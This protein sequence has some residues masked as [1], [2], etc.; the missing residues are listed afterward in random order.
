MKEE[1]LQKTSK[2]KSA[3]TIV[4]I[5]ALAAASIVFGVLYI[6]RTGIDFI[7][8]HSLLIEIL[9]SAIIAVSAV[10]AIVFLTTNKELVYKF[11][12]I[13][14]ALATIFLFIMYIIC[15][16]GLWDKI[17]SIEDLREYVAGYGAYTIPVFILI[18]FLQVVLLPIPG[19]VTIGAGVALFGPFYGSLY[20]F[21][22][23]TSASFVAFF[24]GRKLGV[25]VASWLVGKETLDKWLEIVKGKDKVALTFM[26][27]FPFFPDD[28]LCFVAGLSTM[29]AGYYSVMIVIARLL[30]VFVTSYSFNGNII[31]YNTWWGL[32][33]WAI[34]LVITAGICYYIYKNG[35]KI[36]KFFKKRFSGKN[37][38]KNNTSH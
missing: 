38:G 26:F 7:A 8:N 27:I 30:T 18:Q 34:I 19:M 12:L 1:K 28:V 31:P 21:I 32:L 20:S 17:D 16:T 29:S 23:I 11:L 5:I 2:L 22:G 6:E 4:S 35:D 3:V 14:L 33:I 15:L 37:G 25:K 9:L 36:E 10:L 13:F 24:I